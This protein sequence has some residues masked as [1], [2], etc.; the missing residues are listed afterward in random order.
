MS[1]S[2]S[3]RW[4]KHKR[5]FM[6]GRLRYLADAVVE[7]VETEIEEIGRMLRGL[8]RALVPIA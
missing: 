5:N 7:E 4:E 1:P 8:E 3:V 2:L 6:A